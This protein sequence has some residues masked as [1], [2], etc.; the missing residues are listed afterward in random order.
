VPFVHA[1]VSG[2]IAT[3]ISLIPLA[4]STLLGE[5]KEEI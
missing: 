5:I 1:Y 4:L 2:G 3:D